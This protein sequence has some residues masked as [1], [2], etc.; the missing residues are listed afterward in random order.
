MSEME[1]KH[2]LETEKKRAS[3]IEA[4][5]AVQQLIN[6]IA[7]LLSTLSPGSGLNN[8]FINAN[9]ESVDAFVSFDATTGLATFVKN[10]GRILIADASRIDALNFN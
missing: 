7:E 9:S 5:S 3:E 8:V 1:I 10:K 6:P 4:P 2:L